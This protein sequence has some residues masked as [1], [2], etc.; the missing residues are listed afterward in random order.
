MF[1]LSLVLTLLTAS[2]VLVKLLLSLLETHAILFQLAN[3]LETQL[4]L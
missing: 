3:L 2:I 1:I 4:S